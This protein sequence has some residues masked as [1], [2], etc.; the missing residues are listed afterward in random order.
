MDFLESLEKVDQ[1]QTYYE[2]IPNLIPVKNR[3][4]IATT[5]I[6]MYV[7]IY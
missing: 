4:F 1:L 7:C 6:G 2:T 5:H 3:S